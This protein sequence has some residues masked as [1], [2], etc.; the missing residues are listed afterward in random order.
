MPDM[1]SIFFGKFNCHDGLENEKQ[2]GQ[3]HSNYFLPQALGN[4]TKKS[5][6]RQQHQMH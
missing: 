2:F 3:M 6:G 4:V 5:L 1:A